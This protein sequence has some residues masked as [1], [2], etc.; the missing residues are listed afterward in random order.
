MHKG[1]NV[2]TLFNDPTGEMDFSI[3]L[4]YRYTNPYGAVIYTNSLNWFVYRTFDN[5]TSF[6]VFPIVNYQ[7]DLYMGKDRA[8]YQ[9]TKYPKKVDVLCVFQVDLIN[10][11]APKFET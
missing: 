3:M 10:S 2:D 9:V 5:L 11:K 6:E 7:G 8:R 1:E 4:S